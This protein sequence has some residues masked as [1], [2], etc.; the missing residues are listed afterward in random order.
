MK[1]NQIVVNHNDRTITVSKTFYSKAA[2][3]G[4]AEYKALNGAIK[5]NRG[6]EVTFKTYEKKSYRGLSL[7]RMADYIKTQPNSEANLIELAKVMEVAK[8]KGSKYPLTKKWFLATFPDYKLNEV[9]ADEKRA[10]QNK[11]ED[12]STSV[13][14]V[15]A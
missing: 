5:Q 13:H 11:S 2:K 12:N 4:T 1:R 8:T 6:Y 10:V 7:E 3:Y 15:P 9:S 14:K